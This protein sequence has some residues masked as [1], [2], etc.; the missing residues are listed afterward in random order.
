MGN[1]LR[2][3]LGFLSLLLLPLGTLFGQNWVEEMQDPA[4][5]FYT[6]QENFETYWSGKEIEKGK[7]WK[8]FKRWENFMEERVR[9]SGV[10]PDPS[11]L[12]RAIQQSLAMQNTTVELGNWKP[13]G[14]FDGNSIGGIG[15][16]NVVAFHPTNNQIVWVGAP[17]GGLW[18]SIDNGLNWTTST[19]QLANLGVSAIAIDPSSPNHM[20]IGTGDRDGGDT[21]SHGLLESFD[22]G[23]TWNTTGLVHSVSSSIRIT[24]LHLNPNNTQELVVA[25]RS[26]MYRSADGGNS[27]NIVTGG[28]FQSLH[29][30]SG[31]PSVLVATTQSPARVHRSAD[32]GATWTLLNST[33]SGLPSS[34]RRMEIGTTPANPNTMYCLVA[35]SNNGFQGLYRSQDAGLTWALRSSS[36]NLLGWSSQGSDSGGQGWY[37][38]AIAVAPD[39]EN[40]I[41]TGGVNIWR[42]NNGGSTWSINA[43]WT[44]SGSADFVH[45]DI[46]DLEFRP[47]TTSLYACS[48]GGLSITTNGSNWNEFQN[49]MN[50]TQ[51]YRIGTTPVDSI[52]TLGGA[53]DNGSHRLNSSGWDRVFGGDGMDCAVD[54][55]DASTQYIS[56]YYGDFFK[57]TNGGNSF[58]GNFNLPPAGNGNWVTPFA[59]DPND[60]NTLYAGFDG[61]WK[62]TNAGASFSNVSGSINGSNF[63]RIFAPKANSQ[64]VYVGIASSVYKSINGGQNFTNMSFAVTGNG[65]I[66]GVAVA[67][68]D[69]DHIWVTR[70][71]YTAGDK[72]FESTDGGTSFT[73]ISGS[74]PNVPVNCVLTLD[75]ANNGVYIGTDVGV[76]YKDNRLND[77]IP[78]MKGFP[79]VIVNDLEYQP[80]S[81]KIKAGTY[82]R[83]LWQ[84]TPYKGDL[85][86]PAASFTATSAT[87]SISDTI[88][89]NST[90][91]NFPKDF[92]WTVF[93]NTFNFVGGTSDTS[94]VAKI[95]VNQ[96]GWYNVSL[97]TSNDN[98]TDSISELAS[99]RAGPLAAP[100]F[101]DFNSSTD[102]DGWKVVNP[103]LNQDL[104]WRQVS[105]IGK[106]GVPTKAAMIDLHTY[107]NNS[108]TGARDH[109]ISPTIDLSFIQNARLYFDFAYTRRSSNS[110]DTLIVSV[111]TDCGTSWTEVS[112]WNEGGTQALATAPSTNSAF[113]PSSAS[114]WCGSPGFAACADVDFSSYDGAT[115][116]QVRFTSVAR[117]GNRLYLDN[118]NL[119]GAAAFVPMVDFTSQTVVCANYD[120]DLM[121]LSGGIIDSLQW[122]L[123]GATPS[124]SNAVNPTVSYAAAGNYSIQLTAYNS[125]GSDSLT[126]NTW[127]TVNGNSFTSI[128]IQPASLCSGTNVDF[129][130][131]L[132]NEGI[133]PELEWFV[134]GSPQAV[135]SSTATLSGLQNGDVV[136]ASLKSSENCAW[137]IV[138]FSDTMV[139]QLNQSPTVSGIAIP[140]LCVGDGPTALQF[141]SPAGGVYS[142]PGVTNGI[143]NPSQAGSGVRIMRYTL[144]DSNE[145][146]GATTRS[147]LISSKPVLVVNNARAC[148]ADGIVT[149]N[150]VSNPPG[151]QYIFNG[152]STSTLD[153]SLLTPGIYSMDYLHTITNCDSTFSFD[154]E[155]FANPAK[156]SILLTG[157]DTLNCLQSA[158]E[159]RWYLNGARITA[160]SGPQWIAA[161][162]G[163]YQVEVRNIDGC[164]TLSDSLNVEGIGLKELSTT[165]WTIFP[166]PN[167]G[168]FTINTSEA[169][170]GSL[171]VVD[172]NG[173]Q[174]TKRKIELLPGN[175]EFNLALS[176]GMY[177]FILEHDQTQEMQRVLIQ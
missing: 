84:S 169:I 76:F 81:D 148:M 26:G 63:D 36:P 17:A 131:T 149:L 129:S 167:S 52:V 86:A 161:G 145:C 61:L 44:G 162:V 73:N 49:G 64:H 79:N 37:D 1:T 39:D 3:S 40:V 122:D 101:E 59:I 14:P 65:S 90:S 24:G 34:G 108:A 154:F 91:V 157:A 41:Y 142:G 132:V 23:Q 50:I 6:V 97:W 102:L 139:I 174:L 164:G 78:F 156:P 75:T 92:K 48:D 67:E 70:S 176:P 136:Y 21:Y 166:N 68:D 43:H 5:N 56:L 54:P 155:V 60:G 62:S 69:E 25:T 2:Y 138:A 103:D 160:A 143:L 120:L 113:N 98:G 13:L 111:S 118:I 163:Q 119:T 10:R 80:L 28:G 47:G 170:I 53:Q 110:F 126:L 117:L 140:A 114:D 144:T 128:Q 83:G 106:Q 171:R 22:G 27:W 82:G 31:D 100:F 15:R 7:G 107:S 57:S 88:Y 115:N 20:F 46:H 109:L 141:G 172:M 152:N 29:Q 85:L 116:L 147:V 177:M 93:P 153:I 18:K 87:C 165:S 159:Y 121:N 134:N 12:M 51:Y 123:P 104:G 99:F 4:V 45:A 125:F 66:T 173:K 35:G 133:N 77:W 158:N 130:A 42:S 168:V 151:G 33:S 127:V 16:L 146:S 175:H 112:R 30:K 135:Q 150:W 95:I 96:N 58:N 9:P 94:E 89:L 8:Q 55:S 137:P 124:T 74:L 19:D 32:G 105:R 11:E 72:V 38:L 71:G